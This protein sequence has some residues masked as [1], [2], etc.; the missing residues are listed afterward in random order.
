M[1]YNLIN[2]LN[3]NETGE[4]NEARSSVCWSRWNYYK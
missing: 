4:Y 1:C 2:E 3:K